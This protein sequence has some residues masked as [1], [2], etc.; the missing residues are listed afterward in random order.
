MQ[1]SYIFKSYKIMQKKLQKR[2]KKVTIQEVTKKS[3][4]SYKNKSYKKVQKKLQNKIVTIGKFVTFFKMIF[5]VA[6]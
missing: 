6:I 3:K 5:T 2:A 1:K 4:K